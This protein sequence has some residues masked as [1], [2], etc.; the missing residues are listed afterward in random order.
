M[1]KTSVDLCKLIG[2]DADESACDTECQIDERISKES[3]R[4]A[5]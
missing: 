2:F 5:A 1:P 4:I 3:L